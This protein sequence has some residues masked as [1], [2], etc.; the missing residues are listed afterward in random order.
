MW[1]R[2]LELTVRA[3]SLHLIDEKSLGD[4]ASIENTLRDDVLETAKYPDIAFKSRGVASERRGDGSYDVRLTGELS[5]HGVRR[6]V[7]V[8]ARVAL[9]GNTLHAIGI[10]SSVSPTS[11]LCCSPL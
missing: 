8:P 7:V 6:T 1:D 3:A 4:R 9:E 2:A 5:W 10:S 11:I